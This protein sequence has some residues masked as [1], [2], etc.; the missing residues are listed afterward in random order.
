METVR[1]SKTSKK[2]L[3]I[4]TYHYPRIEARQSQTRVESL[5]LIFQGNSVVCLRI[6]LAVRCL[7]L[8]CLLIKSK[9]SQKGTLRASVSPSRNKILSSNSAFPTA[10]YIA[11]NGGIG[12]ND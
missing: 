9:Y 10:G 8:I 2:K 3:N 7:L 4:T 5:K 11:S 6:K 12:V 1:F